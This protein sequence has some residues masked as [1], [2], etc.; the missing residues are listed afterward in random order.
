MDITKFI[1]LENSTIVDSSNKH[2]LYVKDNLLID[3]SNNDI[4]TIEFSWGS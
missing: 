1:I 4:Y 2:I 3:A